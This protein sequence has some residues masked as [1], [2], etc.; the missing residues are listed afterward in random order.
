MLETRKQNLLIAVATA[1]LLLATTIP[2]VSAASIEISTYESGDTLTA[3]V[4]AQD[5]TEPV[6]GMAFDLQYDP[7][8]LEYE[9]FEEGAFFEYGGDPIYL[10]TKTIDH[11][12][13]RVIAG[14]TLR[15]T[16]AQVDM[17]GTVI[18]FNFN[19]RDRETTELKFRYPVI[20]RIDESGHRQ[21]LDYVEWINKEVYFREPIQVSIAKEIEQK[22]EE[23][24]GTGE[25]VF[26]IAEI[27]SANIIGATDRTITRGALTA[28]TL[29]LAVLICY[30]AL[31]I[32]RN[33]RR[34]AF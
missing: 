15:R 27:G 2:R 3:V 19:I 26:E 9:S 32:V 13:G 10:V 17:S 33:R 34:E 6:I 18:A 31:R 24:S 21:D 29:P 14:V 25:V 30:I 4:N 8:I 1:V 11:R 5:I 12:G 22:T 16:D 28:M 23:E 20:S 7:Y